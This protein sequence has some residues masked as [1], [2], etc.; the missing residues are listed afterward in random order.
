MY[1]VVTCVEEGTRNHVFWLVHYL[2]NPPF[3]LIHITTVSPVSI[4]D[5]TKKFQVSG[6]LLTDMV[7]TA[8]YTFGEL[9]ST[10]TIS[11]LISFSF[12]EHYVYFFIKLNDS[13]LTYFW[14]KKKNNIT[15]PS[16]A[17]Y[18][19]YLAQYFWCSHSQIA[20]VCAMRT[21]CR[22]WHFSGS[23]FIQVHRM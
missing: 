19:R 13:F 15:C 2:L 5:K 8:T 6:T 23:W 9:F 21:L 12:F 14:P 10:E 11:F 4:S 16:L 20:R 18:L 17:L 1:L 7:V 22:K 3:Y